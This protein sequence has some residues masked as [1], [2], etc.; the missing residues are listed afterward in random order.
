MVSSRSRG[1][2]LIELLIVIAI[3]GILSSTVLVSLNSARA[4]ARDA[5]RLSDLNQVRTALELYYFD[6]GSYPVRAN[7][8]GTTPGCYSG[9]A[10]PKTA[11]PGLV[12]KYLPSMP[13]DPK[14]TGTSYCYLYRS[15]GKDYKFMAYNSAETRTPAPGQPNARYR[16][17]CGSAQR[18]FAVYSEGYGCM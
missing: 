2:T 6:N 3:I 15:D 9:P 4:K 16:S 7:W 10:D 14:P 8:I 1:F 12:P 17:G 11:I 5:R 18:T 13:Q